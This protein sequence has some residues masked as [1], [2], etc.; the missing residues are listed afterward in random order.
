MLLNKDYTLL[1][2]LPRPFH[3]IDGPENTL[4]LGCARDSGAVI[5]EIFIVL[6][7]SVGNVLSCTC[8]CESKPRGVQKKISPVISNSQAF[9]V[10]LF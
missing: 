4:A 10:Y 5:S 8:V 1:V 2:S 6:L 7:S 9:Q 3:L